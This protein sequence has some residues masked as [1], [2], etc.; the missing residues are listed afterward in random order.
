MQTNTIIKV[1]LFHFETREEF[2]EI[3]DIKCHKM[4]S[5]TGNQR[6]LKLSNVEEVYQEMSEK[7][8]N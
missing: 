2:K 4:R 3:I 8:Q 1:Q 5:R 6:T 7:S